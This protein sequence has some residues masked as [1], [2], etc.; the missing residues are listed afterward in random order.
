MRPVI[1]TSLDK[2][3]GDTKIF[4]NIKKRKRTSLATHVSLSINI[5]ALAT[6]NI[7]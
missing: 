2:F 3:L 4:K 7:L 6:Y 1:E 5:Q